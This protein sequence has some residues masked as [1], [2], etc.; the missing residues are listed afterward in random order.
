VNGVQK[1]H[2]ES[3]CKVAAFRT[4]KGDMREMGFERCM[5]RF[6][7]LAEFELWYQHC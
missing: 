4:K 3:I 1:F 5:N 2:E 7:V 6:R